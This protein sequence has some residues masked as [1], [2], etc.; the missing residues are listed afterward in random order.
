MKQKS[1]RDKT[2]A[3]FTCR[4]C[5]RLAAF[6]LIELIVTVAIIGILAM[7]A[8]PY[9]SQYTQ[10]AKI[11]RSQTDLE[12]IKQAFYN[13]YYEMLIAGHREFPPAPAD[14][15]MT[16]S[17]ANSPSLYGG[18]TPASL[19][20]EGRLPMNPFGNPYLYIVLNDAGGR[21]GGFF[22]KD[23]DIGTNVTFVP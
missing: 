2:G 21:V 17:W 12:K 16:S 22:L 11:T 1:P 5:R 19:F 20:S 13:H 7:T 3:F 18:S 6:T 9:Y 14:S 4:Q 15:A 10:Q 23:P 8:A